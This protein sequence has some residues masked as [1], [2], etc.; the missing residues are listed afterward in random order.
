MVSM[1]ITDLSAGAGQPMSILSTSSADI[2]PRS[3]T[4]LPLTRRSGSRWLGRPCGRK[5]IDGVSE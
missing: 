1:R 2:S 4:S 3:M 5:V